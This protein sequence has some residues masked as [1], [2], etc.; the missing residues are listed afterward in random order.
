MANAAGI[1]HGPNGTPTQENLDSMIAAFEYVPPTA[2]I[3]KKIKELEKYIDDM[4]EAQKKDDDSAFNEA[5]K[6]FN[7]KKEELLKWLK[8]AKESVDKK[9][10]EIIDPILQSIQDQIPDPIKAICDVDLFAPSITPKV[11]L[12]VDCLKNMVLAI[13]YPYK[14]LIKVV[15]WWATHFIPKM[16]AYI[17]KRIGDVTTLITRVES[18]TPPSLS[19]ISSKL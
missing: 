7:E 19:D 6:K 16:T 2:L 15:Q 8:E 12:S 4:I 1:M 9:I 18:L 10:H 11:S 3:D 5:K 13:V 14:P 17:S